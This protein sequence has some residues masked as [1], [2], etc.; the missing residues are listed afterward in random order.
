M[1]DRSTLGLNWLNL[2]VALM[3]TGFGAFLA[4]YLATHGWNSAEV[5]F[6]LS[7]GAL[8]AMVAQVPGGMM[9]DAAPSKRHAA[10]VA[11][12][13][14]VA[15]AFTIGLWPIEGPVLWAE[16]MQGAASCVLGPAIAAITLAL[17]HKEVLGE[18]LG[19]N[20][21]F[22]ALG[23]V[24]AA[25]AMGAIGTWYSHR[26][27]LFLAG[28]AGIAALGALF[29]IRPDDLA[30]APTR[31]DHRGAPPKRLRKKQDSSWDVACDRCLLTFGLCVGLFALGNAALLPLA[32]GEI[33]RGGW[34]GVELIVAAAIVVPQLIA[35]TLSPRIGRAAQEHGR[36][37]VLVVGI[38][39]MTLRAILLAFD[40]GPW[41]LIGFQALDGITA[42]VMG[43]L[44]PLIVADITHHRGR[45]NL[46]MGIVGLFMGVGAVLST[47]IG[48]AIADRFGVPIAF[49]ALSIP[50]MI[51]C[52]VAW[53][54][55]PETRHRPLA[56]PA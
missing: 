5:G 40:G 31:T 22:A 50:G 4:V 53:T 15:A 36:R 34:R 18:R 14:V 12:L 24:I 49:A 10:G 41:L 52:A 29:A 35:A 38:G 30:A 42:A 47:T 55:L 13:M 28:V 27:T 37:I 2:L 48:G 8:A 20:V 32:A 3:Q 56:K 39:A 25:L 6:A 46:A 17:A 19:H 7:A 21:R 1:N 44:V 54:M 11:I 43:V 9:V 51:A 33:A 26:A 23:S 16:L 45:F